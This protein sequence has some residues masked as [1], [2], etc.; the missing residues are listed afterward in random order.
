MQ[1]ISFSLFSYQE[2]FGFDTKLN[3]PEQLATFT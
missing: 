3:D 1:G 2:V